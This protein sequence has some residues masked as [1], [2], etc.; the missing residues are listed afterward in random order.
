MTLKIPEL[1][2]EKQHIIL[3]LFD[4]QHHLLG[5]NLIS[6]PLLLAMLVGADWLTVH[7]VNP[8]LARPLLPHSHN[9]QHLFLSPPLT[10]SE[11]HTYELQS[12]SQ[13]VYR[14]LLEE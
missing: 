11:E 2:V 5:V 3:H 8:L 13:L 4:Q 12:R 6:L 1:L 7:I 9:H 10:R 14:L